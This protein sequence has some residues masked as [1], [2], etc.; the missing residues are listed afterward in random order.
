MKKILLLLCFISST[1]G[2]SQAVSDSIDL[3]Q[4][5]KEISELPHFNVKGV[6]INQHMNIHSTKDN[7]IAKGFNADKATDIIFKQYGIY[8]IVGSFFGIP[9]CNIKIIPLEN[10]PTIVRMIAVTFPSKV[11]FNSLKREY[12][13]IKEGLLQKYYM[14]YSEEQFFDDYI[15]KSDSESLRWSAFS[16]DECRFQSRFYVSD[17]PYAFV[18]GEA[19]LTISYLHVGDRG[20]EAYVT[21]VYL[22]P[23]GADARTHDVDDL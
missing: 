19:V 15:N 11:T 16:K 4:M 14:H 22:T 6:K 23:D 21:L 12:D 9:N 7:L 20:D 13:L 3:V 5:F 8:R 10:D 2:Y 18:R 1:I 17:S